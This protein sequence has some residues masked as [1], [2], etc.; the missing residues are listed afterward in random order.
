MLSLSQP[1]IQRAAIQKKR[2]WVARPAADSWL[3]RPDASLRKFPTTA[4][5]GLLRPSQMRSTIMAMMVLTQQ[6]LRTSTAALVLAEGAPAPFRHTYS[7]GTTLVV[8]STAEGTVRIKTVPRGASE[9][10]PHVDLT[11]PQTQPPPLTISPKGSLGR[12]VP[13]PFR[14]GWRLST[15]ELQ[16]LVAPDA[17]L[18][19]LLG[20]D[21]TVLSSELAPPTRLP[22]A[23]CGNTVSGSGQGSG[24]RIPGGCLRA[25]R[26]LQ[27]GEEMFGGGVQLYSG[28]AQRGKRLFLRT[29][30]QVGPDGW[31]HTVAPLFFSS[32]GY[33]FLV[34]T[35][36]YTY[37]DIGATYSGHHAKP[38]PPGRVCDTKYSD[39]LGG[40]TVPLELR[41]PTGGKIA[42][43]SFADYGLSTGDCGDGFAVDPRCSQD[44]SAVVQQLCLGRSECSLK[45][46]NNCSHCA[47]NTC[48]PTCGDPCWGN[49]HKHLS[50][51]ATCA[52][53]APKP[54]PSP[55][56]PVVTPG[57]NLIHVGDPVMDLYFFSGPSHHDLL[58]Q[59]TQLTGR[60]SLPPKWAL[61]LWYHPQEHS[62]QSRVLEI[63]RDFQSHKV[64]LAALTLEPP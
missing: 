29:N 20:H 50:V 56:P 60:M 45:V 44:W 13:T 23:Q 37:F 18:T 55:P 63:V 1:Q 27:Q 17:P 52:G 49:A 15:P 59:Y 6:L 38:T 41:C 4:V 30:A 34:N 8:A 16:V 46:A 19:Q 57:A 11:L 61:G 53:Q 33:G 28:P 25:S 10:F 48:S 5:C 39:K 32:R 36:A 26:S 64:P 21:G 58:R 9:A 2:A 3:I 7:D 40:S 35:H 22:E 14:G 62:N 42:N 51:S 47:N 31:S 24:G 54:P 43:V 12:E